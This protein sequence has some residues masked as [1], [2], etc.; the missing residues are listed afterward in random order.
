MS[1]QAARRILQLEFTNEDR[2]RVRSLTERNQHGRLSDD[3]QTELDEFCRVATLLS[4]LKVR[5]RRIL[6]S[7]KRA[8]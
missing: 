4:L 6:K 5:A 3:E 2:A 1:R 7:S 8:S